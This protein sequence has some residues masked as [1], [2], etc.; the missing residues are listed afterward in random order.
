MD[1]STIK[2]KRIYHIFR[3]L[4]VFVTFMP[5]IVYIIIGFANND[6]YVG[7]KIVLSLSMVIA[8]LICGMNVLFKYHLR[9]PLF[10]LLIG[11]YVCVDKILLLII[12]LSCGIVLDEFVFTPIAKKYKN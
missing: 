1:K 4:S 3:I 6:I 7:K 2:Y 5:L 12:I 10:L 8:I 11:V 9:S